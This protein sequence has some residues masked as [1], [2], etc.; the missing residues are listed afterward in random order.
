MCSFLCILATL[1]LHYIVSMPPEP[2]LD[3]YSGNSV[4]DLEPCCYDYMVLSEERKQDI[5][6]YRCRRGDIIL[7]A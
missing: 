7:D 1:L 6:S 3:N 4:F 5:E 2:L